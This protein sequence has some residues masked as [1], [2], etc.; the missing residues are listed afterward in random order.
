MRLLRRLLS[1]VVLT[2]V[3]VVGW[4]FAQANPTPV[5]IELPYAGLLAD[6]PL[7]LALGVAFGAGLV[8]A[9]LLGL[10]PLMRL[11]LRARRHRKESERLAAEVHQLRNLP[12]S[13]EGEGPPRG[14]AGAAPDAAASARSAGRGG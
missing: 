10:L 6:V 2:A 9:G 4:M 13:S 3:V 7:W 11:G 12:L 14:S 5:A 1:L 8:L